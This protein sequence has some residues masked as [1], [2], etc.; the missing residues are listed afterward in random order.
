MRAEIASVA[1][2]IGTFRKKITRQL[3]M[4][5]SQPPSSGPI[6]VEMPLQ[7]VHVPIAAPRSVPENVDV[8]SASDAGV[9]SAPAMPCRPRK[10]IS[11]STFGA[12]AQSTDAR[13]NQ[14][15]A[16]PE[17][18]HLAEDVPERP[19]D[20]DQRAEREQIGVHDPL[21]GGE[22]AAQIVLN[23]RQS[24]VHDRSVDEDDR[25]AQDRRDQ[26]QPCRSR[27]VSDT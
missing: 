23:R 17:D 8:M 6:T 19:A 27:H 4:P 11:V 12:T 2:A 14:R 1:I 21:L 25:G 20:E 9:K 18:P 26:R 7:A 22:P 3:E 16:E 13:P 10:T 5:I 24:D 15:D